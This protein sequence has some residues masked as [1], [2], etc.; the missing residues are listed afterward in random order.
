MAAHFASPALGPDALKS[1]HSR[2]DKLKICGE[3][4]GLG[5]VKQ[6]DGGKGAL[7]IVRD[8][9]CSKC[10]GEGMI[11]VGPPAEREAFYAEANRKP[12]TEG[13]AA[14]VSLKDEGDALAKSGDWAKAAAKY[15]EARGLDRCYLPAL[16]N[17]ALCHLKLADFGKCVA[18]CSYVI[19]TADKGSALRLKAHLRRATASVARGERADMGV[20][21]MISRRCSRAAGPPGGAAAGGGPKEAAFLAAEKEALLGKPGDPKPAEA[22]ATD[23]DI[24][25]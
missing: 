1:A 3:C 24:L 4:Q 10:R 14:A 17:R 23:F 19:A 2:L 13:L 6:T 21:L 18:D 20:A 16:A 7:H 25:D 22:G 8:V 5:M 11:F 12:S 9:N 15:S